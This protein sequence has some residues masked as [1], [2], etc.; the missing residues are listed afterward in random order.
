[1][2]W[3]ASMAVFCM[4]PTHPLFCCAI[5]LNGVTCARV[6]VGKSR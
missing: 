6:R 4:K 5:E 1:M 3:M 2:Q